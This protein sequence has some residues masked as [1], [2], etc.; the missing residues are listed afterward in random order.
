MSVSILS[1]DEVRR[2]L[3]V[4]D[5][6]DPTAGPHAMQRLV[7]AALEAL[8]HAW[9]CEVRVHRQSPI[10]SIV[11]NYDHLHYPPE[12]AARD[13][14]YTRY[15]CDTALL[16]TQTSAAGLSRACLPARLH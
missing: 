14:R 3:S 16:R 4:R 8:R 1:A 12:G 2:A 5:L 9:G 7:E 10:V 13:A 11:D 6:T 15:V